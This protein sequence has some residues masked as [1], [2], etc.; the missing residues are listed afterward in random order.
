M[1][2]FSVGFSLFSPAA[3]VR[4]TLSKGVISQINDC[5]LRT[6]CS[7]HPGASGGAVVLPD[8]RLV[9]IIVCNARLDESGT[10]YPR[11][12]MAIPIS[13]VYSSIQNYLATE[14]GFDFCFFFSFLLELSFIDKTFKMNIM[15]YRLHFKLHVETQIKI[16]L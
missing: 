15:L 3:N 13:N 12:N 14:G 11:I 9:G 4:P 7:V 16:S 2:V 10:A 6:T 1:D 5:M 8:G